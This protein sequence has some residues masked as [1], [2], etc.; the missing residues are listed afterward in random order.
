MKYISINIMLSKQNI[1]VNIV[2]INKSGYK[3]AAKR[4]SVRWIELAKHKDEK[5]HLIDMK[6]N[7]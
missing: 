3:K 5:S 2:L 7:T 4:W 1:M 6:Q